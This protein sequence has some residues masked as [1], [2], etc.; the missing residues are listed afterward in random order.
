MLGGGGVGGRGDGEDGLLAVA[1]VLLV[2]EPEV[3]DAIVRSVIGVGE[4]LDV[5]LLGV[6][7]EEEDAYYWILEWGVTNILR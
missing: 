6:G 7:L 2:G 4:P 3:V 1:V 5:R